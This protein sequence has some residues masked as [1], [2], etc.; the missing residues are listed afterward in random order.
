MLGSLPLLD[1]DVYVFEASL[2]MC[3]APSPTI[4]TISFSIHIAVI[5]VV[6]TSI[7]RHLNPK[8]NADIESGQHSSVS[9]VAEGS[10]R[11]VF[12]AEEKLAH[13]VLLY[14]FV[15]SLLILVALAFAITSVIYQNKWFGLFCIFVMGIA[16]VVQ[17]SILFSRSASLRHTANAVAPQPDDISSITQNILP[18]IDINKGIE[19]PLFRRRSFSTT[20]HFKSKVSDSDMRIRSISTTCTSSG[21]KFSKE[22]KFHTTKCTDSLSSNKTRVSIKSSKSTQSKTSSISIHLSS[23]PDSK[24]SWTRYTV[25]SIETPISDSYFFS[26]K[27]Y[28][29][30]EPTKIRRIVSEADMTKYMPSSYYM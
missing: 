14:T 25:S 9:D 13:N 21:T 30:V 29:N 8:Y 11:N 2:S 20:L 18:N 22:S 24:P 4:F 1:D 26:V 10:D 15:S 28:R 6:C 19:V 16:C 27:R 7:H 17:P 3:T 12:E 23:G 5:I